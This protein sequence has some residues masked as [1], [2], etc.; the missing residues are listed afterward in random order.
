[1]VRKELRQIFRD[2]QL[3]RILFVAPVVQLLMFGYAV[4]TDVRHTRTFVVDHAHDAASRRVVE[5]LTAGGFFDVVGSSDRD[6]DVVEALDHGRAVV[7]LVIPP[8]LAADLARAASAEC[9]ASG[10]AGNG[11]G[12]S[13]R[14]CGATLQLLVDGTNSNVATVALGQAEGILSALGI[15]LAP[16]AAAGAALRPPIELRDRAWYNP[17]LAS[18][19]YNVPGVVGVLLFLVC[20][21]L[22]ALAVVRERELGTLEQLMVTPLLPLELVAGK[23]LPFALIG[24]VDLVLVTLLAVLWF[25][26]PFAGSALLLFFATVL[27]LVP[28]L[29]LGL[30]ISTTSKTQQEAFMASYLTLVPAILLSGFMFPVASMPPFFRALSLAN[31][32]RHYLEIVRGIFLKGVGLPELWRPH[33]WLLGL[34]LVFVSVAAS[35]FQKRIA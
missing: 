29:G 13:G 18:R 12:A 30:L 14:G 9:G 15:A 35:R 10:G 31:P 5:A 23:A 11:S 27:F 25:G 21:L 24:L 16:P 20:M 22:T 28:S 3:Y 34:G 33:L 7:G 1:M 8:R 4:S 17:D 6:A 19:D 32:L 26:V 2:P